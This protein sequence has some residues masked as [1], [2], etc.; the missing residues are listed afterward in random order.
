MAC[1]LVDDSSAALQ[2]GCARRSEVFI[3]RRSTQQPSI[4]QVTTFTDLAELP[5]LWQAQ[6]GYRVKGLVSGT[7]ASMPPRY[8]S[9]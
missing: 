4:I 9:A 7:L 6:L 3:L 1:I 5:A 8:A 2:S